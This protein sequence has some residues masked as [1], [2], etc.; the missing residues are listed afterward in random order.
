MALGDGERGVVDGDAGAL[1]DLVVNRHH[2]EAE[3]LVPA[4]GFTLAGVGERDGHRVE[5]GLRRD[6][7]G[8]DDLHELLLQ[9]GLSLA[10]V[11]AADVLGARR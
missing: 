4:V 2:L 5:H 6:V 10:H 11:A 3:R 8:D 9:N 7:R 1:V